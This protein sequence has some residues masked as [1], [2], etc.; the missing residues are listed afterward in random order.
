MHFLP[1][2]VVKSPD[3]DLHIS[4]IKKQ[5]LDEAD[6]ARLWK[7]FA[8]VRRT[9]IDPTIQANRLENFW[10][11][12]W[13]SKQKHLSGLSLGKLCSGISDESSDVRLCSSQGFVTNYYPPKKYSNLHEKRHIEERALNPV[14]S[15][16]CKS[17]FSNKSN[18]TGAVPHPI[19]KKTRGTS[20][21]GHRPTARFISPHETEDENHNTCQTTENIHQPASILSG[22]ATNERKRRIEPNVSKKKGAFVITKKKQAVILRRQSPSLSTDAANKVLGITRAANGI[23]ISLNKTNSFAGRQIS[24][25]SRPQILE[26]SSSISDTGSKNTTSNSIKSKP[27]IAVKVESDLQKDSSTEPIEYANSVEYQ[28][29][30]K[31][32]TLSNLTLKN[33]N[34]DIPRFSSNYVSDMKLPSSQRTK[35]PIE[36]TP[37]SN[38]HDTVLA[39]SPHLNLGNNLKKPS[40]GQRGSKVEL[41]TLRDETNDNTTSHLKAHEVH[42]NISSNKPIID[43]INKKDPYIFS[44]APQCIIKSKLSDRKNFRAP[45]SITAENIF[46]KMP[47]QSTTPLAMTSMEELSRSKSQLTL[48]LE[49]DRASIGEK[50]SKQAK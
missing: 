1:R 5:P 2:I 36:T 33:S 24:G 4:R 26:V 23:S 46:A 30:F 14:T 19:L 44:T 18:T 8:T 29:K 3:I 40:Q 49:R 10:W 43:E 7:V 50:S 6:I 15:K 9:I 47:I 21:N 12:V 27:F 34:D 35:L 16:P 45:V 48:L 11:R 32:D 17:S 39:C 38:K 42:S 13:G 25:R 28:Q 31:S 20:T 22:G 41:H 37:S